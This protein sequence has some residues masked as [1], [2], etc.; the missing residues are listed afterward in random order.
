MGLFLHSINNHQIEHSIV[1]IRENEIHVEEITLE[2]VLFSEDYQ[3]E[4]NLYI[5]NH[6][7]FKIGWFEK[8]LVFDD[9][10]MI[11]NTYFHESDF[12]SPHGEINI[13]ESNSK[14]T[15]ISISS[16][17]KGDVSNS[18]QS[19][20]LVI[21][22]D[23][24]T[25]SSEALTNDWSLIYGDIEYS[26]IAGS[27]FWGLYIATLGII[28]FLLISLLITSGWK[29]HIIICIIPNMILVLIRIF[30][31]GKQNPL[32]LPFELWKDVLQPELYS[33]FEYHTQGWSQQ[34]QTIPLFEI[35]GKLYGYQFLPGFIV[36]IQLFS[37]IPL[38]PAWK[39]GLP[40][41]LANIGIACICSKIIFQITHSERKRIISLYAYL[42]NPIVMVYGNFLWLNT[43]LYLF[44]VMLALWFFI[45]EIFPENESENNVDNTYEIKIKEKD[46]KMDKKTQVHK[47]IHFWNKISNFHW[48]Y[49]CLS[50]AALIKQFSIILV[51]LFLL[52]ECRYIS[53]N[54]NVRKN[55]GKKYPHLKLFF[56]DYL[57]IMIKSCLFYIVPI[58]LVILPYLFVNAEA[59]W[60]LAIKGGVTFNIQR[61]SI[62]HFGVG[63]SII[64]FF[65]YIGSPNFIL[66]IIGY[67]TIFWVLFFIANLVILR[68]FWIKSIPKKADDVNEEEI[69]NDKLINKDEQKFEVEQLE[70]K[71]ELS[72]HQIINLW[73]LCATAI[74]ISFQ[75]FYPR[76]S[77]KYYL[78]ALVPFITLYLLSLIQSNDQK[79]G[80]NKKQD[81]N[82]EK[83][84]WVKNKEKRNF[85][86]FILMSTV[87]VLIL[88]Y[89]YLLFLIGYLFFF[90]KQYKSEV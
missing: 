46:E 62:L 42:F 61:I 81:G 50:I 24:N 70:E 30:L 41:I 22:G 51:P 14:H 77:Y 65:S 11:F 20:F 71:K 16:R 31:Q 55:I 6:S 10:T 29:K 39:L 66:N 40:M 25:I 75:L 21:Y 52:I 69:D 83:K 90:I 7:L 49:I 54:I 27:Y 74:F 87:I 89:I 38:L 58:I 45:K 13:E 56:K 64:S 8:S 26:S 57:P 88:R 78:I 5:T 73:F 35:Y 82:K 43:S 15:S 72:W 48:G 23:I 67:L 84:Q 80:K 33:D 47:K 32:F 85:I 86:V 19:R 18:S 1:N 36:I 17:I 76:G 60:F 2:P 4:L 63:V 28:G 44:F 79:L 37:Y 12:Y 34:F 59:F 9:T 68:K 3:I 53:K